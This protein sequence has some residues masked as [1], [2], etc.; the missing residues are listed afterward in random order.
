MFYKPLAII[1]GKRYLCAP[2]R[3]ILIPDGG[4]VFRN[5]LSHERTT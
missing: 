4:A 1:T 3:K 2:F 5:F